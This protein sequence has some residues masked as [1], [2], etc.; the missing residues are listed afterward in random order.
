MA[1][2]LLPLAALTLALAGCGGSSPPAELAGLWSA[3]PSACAAGVGVRFGP[4]AIEA[5]YEEQRE[6]LF[7]R[8]RYQV[9]AGKTL[10]IRIVYD[11]PRM[12]GGARSTG[13]R[14]VLILARQPGGGIAPI[15]HN[16]T[17]ART[18]AARLRMRDDPAIGLLTLQPCAGEPWREDLR[19]RG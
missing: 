13:A 17:D 9:E 5:V 18:G 15:A 10:R 3:G 1:R 19:G 6:T 4:R 14:G 12:P 2:A 7:E 11:L 16:L 8:P